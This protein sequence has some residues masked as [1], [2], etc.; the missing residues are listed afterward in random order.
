MMQ[1]RSAIIDSALKRAGIIDYSADWPSSIK[2]PYKY[3]KVY[4]YSNGNIIYDL[5]GAIIDPE[6]YTPHSISHPGLNM[7]HFLNPTY[8]AHGHEI[9]QK[10][11]L[12]EIRSEIKKYYQYYPDKAKLIEKIIKIFGLD[13][14]SNSA[15]GIYAECLERGD[16]IADD[17]LKAF[18][19]YFDD[20]QLSKIRPSAEPMFPWECHHVFTNGTASDIIK[21]DGP[22]SYARKNTP[23][24]DFTIPISDIDPYHFHGSDPLIMM[25][26]MYGLISDDDMFEALR[27][28]SRIDLF[29]WRFD[30]SKIPGIE[31]RPYFAGDCG[32]TVHL[33]IS[34]RGKTFISA[35]G[36]LE[37]VVI[38]AITHWESEYI[39]NFVIRTRHCDPIL[40]CAASL[41]SANNGKCGVI[42]RGNVLLLANDA[43]YEECL[44][45]QEYFGPQKFIQMKQIEN[46]AY[47][48]FFKKVSLE[49]HTFRLV[50][51]QKSFQNWF[52]NN[53]LEFI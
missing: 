21:Y 25:Y 6:K 18:Q 35:V 53:V 39:E 44:E 34:H 12:C 38:R 3:R 47:E 24:R 52:T 26:I 43:T 5:S 13:I 8:E 30:I 31:I 45:F 46:V 15:F 42:I 2:S 23:K 37:H 19:Q 22:W 28:I 7:K 11:C 32:I 48:H 51:S 17:W 29:M 27:G 20:D 1:E 33:K 9:Q 50:A 14:I 16:E 40:S 49:R 10:V 41:R 36:C 4:D